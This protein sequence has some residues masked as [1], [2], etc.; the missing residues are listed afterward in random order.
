MAANPQATFGG[1]DVL[2]PRTEA[3]M[4]TGQIS[5]VPL[6]NNPGFSGLMVRVGALEADRAA[7]RIVRTWTLGAGELY[8]ADQLAGYGERGYYELYDENQPVEVEDGD[9]QRFEWNVLP[10]VRE[11]AAAAT[12]NARGMYAFDLSTATP[13]EVQGIR[14]FLGMQL[15]GGAERANLISADDARM[16]FQAS[17]LTSAILT[18]EKI[19]PR[20]EPVALAT[21]RMLR[22]KTQELDDEYYT[23]STAVLTV[24]AVTDLVTWEVLDFAHYA[25]RIQPT[26]RETGLRL[27]REG[28][29]TA[30][31]IWRRLLGDRPNFVTDYFVRMTEQLAL[32]KSYVSDSI[33]SVSV[34]TVTKL[35]GHDM[36][37]FKMALSTL[38]STGAQDRAHE[39]TVA[40]P[41]WNGVPGREAS[42]RH[43]LWQQ[44]HNTREQASQMQADQEAMVT[45]LIEERTQA[46]KRELENLRQGPKQKK[47]RGREDPDG[48]EEPGVSDRDQKMKAWTKGAR[49]TAKPEPPELAGEYLVTDRRCKQGRVLIDKVFLMHGKTGDAKKAQIILTNQLARRLFPGSAY[50]KYYDVRKWQLQENPALVTEAISYVEKQ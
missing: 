33:E 32:L 28:M 30:G 25:R 45:R 13:D 6:P 4:V 23:R 19:S 10:C 18:S 39:L 22:R 17:H 16:L 42:R 9:P 29:E 41:A 36:L 37:A 46:L 26:T 24:G 7:R 5:Y 2:G 8:E 1:L 48:S 50:A 43:N 35:I 3:Q 21:Q 47:R 12:G 27:I 40:G 20:K 15:D 34:T 11:A 38:A 31:L 44:H 14:A 49:L